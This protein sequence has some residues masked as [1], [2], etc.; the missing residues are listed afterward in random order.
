VAAG[1]QEFSDV[2]LYTPGNVVWSNIVRIDVSKAK[3][4][5]APYAQYD[6]RVF[7]EFTRKGKRKA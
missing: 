1:L 4:W 5:I 6:E 2:T 7:V 3:V